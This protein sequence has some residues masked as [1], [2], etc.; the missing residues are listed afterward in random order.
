MEQPASE[1]HNKL[2][3]SSFGE[4]EQLSSCESSK[5]YAHVT[6]TDNSDHRDI[7]SHLE[8]SVIVGMTDEGRILST[9][10][11]PKPIY[12]SFKPEHG[13][14]VSKKLSTLTTHTRSDLSDLTSHNVTCQLIPL[15]L[16]FMM[17]SMP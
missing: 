7:W 13:W 17:R 14:I 4:I 16:H 5:C 9:I 1:R 2:D 15:S 10:I 6:K 3:F 8:P 12:Q 11:L